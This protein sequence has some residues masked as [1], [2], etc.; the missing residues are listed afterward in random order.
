MSILALWATPRTVSTAFER[1]MIER[2][3]HLALDEPW[4]RAYYLGPDR[5][6][7]RF[8][9]VFPESTY[10]AVSTGVRT[11]GADH[12]VFVKDMAYQAAPGLTDDDLA[13]AVHTFLIRDPVAAIASLAREWPDHTEDEAGYIAQGNL[14]DRVVEVTGVVPTVIDSDL[15]RRDPE[16]VVAEWCRRV[17]IDHLSE[18]LTWSAGHRPEWPLWHTWYERV[19]RSTGFSPPDDDLAARPTPQGSDAGLIE[20]ASD[21]YRRLRAYAIGA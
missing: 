1:M 7:P 19:A 4:S 2:G 9:L 11:T 15:L 17:G 10:E 8:P 21:V 3:D 16:S 6:S 20:R 18:S 5:R 14:F 13:N 12:T